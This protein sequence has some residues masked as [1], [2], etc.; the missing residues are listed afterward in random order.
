MPAVLHRAY[1][2]RSVFLG[3]VGLVLLFGAAQLALWAGRVSPATF[4][5]PSAVLGS[6]ANLARN[7]SVRAGVGSTMKEWAEA[8]AIAV[9]I[10][11]PVGLLLGTLPLLEAA[12]RPVIEFVRPVPAVVLVPLV[13]LIIQDN[14]RTEVAVVA[15]AS[16]WPVLINTIYGVR[17][18]D[19]LAVE[20][21]RSFGFGP[22]SV[23]RLVSLPSAAPFI[24]TG[25][26]VAASFAFVVAVAVELIGTGMGGIGAFAAQEE[27]GSGDMAVMIA[28]AVWTGLIGLAVN[29]VFAAAGRRLFRWHFALTATAGAQS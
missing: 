26:R 28:I 15:F 20:T 13:L 22:L 14:Q 27:S 24:A 7:G 25:V 5:L 9:V 11:V 23:A 18:V 29:G 3:A 6:F 21:L 1:R 2:G 16:G 8:M 4:P 12:V 10:A 19:P 17:S